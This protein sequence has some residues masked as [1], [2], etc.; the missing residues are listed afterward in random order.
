[1][2]WEPEEERIT[3]DVVAECVAQMEAL[4]I[5]GD[6]AAATR[7]ERRIWRAALSA[8]ADGA[9]DTA[10]LATEALQTRKYRFRR[11]P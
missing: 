10:A 11:I 1:M 3:P 9:W 2:S 6:A 7:A 4:V 8:I 5:S